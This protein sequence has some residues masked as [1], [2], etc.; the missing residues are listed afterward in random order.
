V[1]SGRSHVQSSWITIISTKHC[2]SYHA[3]SFSYV[4]APHKYGV[5]E[6]WLARDFATRY[7]GSST[8]A[9]TQFKAVILLHFAIPRLLGT[10]PKGCQSGIISTRRS[11]GGFEGVDVHVISGGET[12]KLYHDPDTEL[13][14]GP[15][16]R[17][18]YVEA[19]TGATFKVK[20]TISKQ[21][22]LFNLR[23][24][25]AVRASINYDGQKLDW[26]RD[27]QVQELRQVWRSGQAQEHNFT[28]FRSLCDQTQQWQEGETS[29]GALDTSEV[30]W[31]HLP[32][33]TH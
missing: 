30:L 8:L 31:R 6:I 10:R 19:I 22:Q 3:S 27:F 7:E 2:L 20:V 29:F 15:R 17:Q 28:A 25:D 14:Q 12:L 9:R 11:M 24:D 4:S 21:F 26:F 16:T 32:C 33:T 18:Q 1:D 23:P 5:V 13:N